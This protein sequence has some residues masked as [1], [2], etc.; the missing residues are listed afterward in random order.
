MGKIAELREQLLKKERSCTEI[1]E[2]YL[3]AI[4]SA[5]PA[6]NAYVK[7]TPEEALA[8][9]GRVDQKLS[10][11]EPLAPLEG[12]PMALKDNISTKGLE[13]TCCSKILKGYTPIYDATV[14]AGLKARNAVLL[15][16]VN[17]DEF[18]M[19]SSS[20]TSCFGPPKNPF[21]T[22]H[23]A[24]GSS[25]GAASAVAGGLA[26][27]ALG[28][29]TGGSIRQPASFCGLTGLKPTYGAVSRYGLIA[30]ASSFDQIGP[31]ALCAQ[32]A[33]EV[34]DAIS[35]KDPMDSTST[36]AAAAALPQLEQP[37]AGKT[38]G[39]AREYF[40]GVREEVKSAVLAA[41]E[42]YCSLGAEVVELSLP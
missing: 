2:E 21:D 35:G 12:I 23:V 9:A 28:S 6:L 11:G 42:V 41:A 18:A 30:Y 24:G 40:D 36:G 33:A 5:N 3:R 25:G 38:V 14:W 16:K 17:M 15:G 27:Y 13:T 10:A 22:G 39:L 4:E 1:T 7:T 32:D 8:A 37:L 20:E 31:L 26:I 34:F 29:D 19:G